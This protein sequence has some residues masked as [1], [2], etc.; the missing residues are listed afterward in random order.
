MVKSQQ[1]EDVL[2]LAAALPREVAK[3][4]W[5]APSA[6]ECHLC[7]LDA[8]NWTSTD[9]LDQHQCPPAELPEQDQDT[10]VD[11]PARNRFW[12]SGFHLIFLPLH[13]L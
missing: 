2:A 6:H 11:Q 9:P 1:R 12:T 7:C 3:T 4:H 13:S 10:T 8:L 5:R